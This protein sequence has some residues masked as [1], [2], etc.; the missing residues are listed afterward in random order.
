MSKWKSMKQFLADYLQSGRQY[1]A[2]SIYQAYIDECGAEISRKDFEMFLR[3]EVMSD[4]GLLRR[5]A[6]GI[7][8]ARVDPADRGVLFTRGKAVSDISDI[9]EDILYSQYKIDP[10]K[11]N[12]YTVLDDALNLTARFHGVLERVEQMP[13]LLPAERKELSVIRVSTLRSMDNAISGVTAAMAWFEDHLEEYATQ[14]T[15]ENDL[16]LV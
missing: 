7:Y 13:D 10:Q 11:E 5:A 1:K 3:S 14:Q 4:N 12:L 16:R 15:E 6:H 8:E 2:G 9:A